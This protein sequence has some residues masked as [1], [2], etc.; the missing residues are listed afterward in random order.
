MKNSIKPLWKSALC[1]AACSAV[2][3]ACA[4]GAA[5]PG[6]VAPTP[7]LTAAAAAG[8]QASD[9]AQL[10]SAFPQVLALVLSQDPQVRGARET[11]NVALAELR[12]SRSRLFPTA[13]V[14]SSYGDA[15]QT[16][17]NT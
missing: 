13:G 1:A 9:A 7:A 6:T 17:L 8:S 12:Q 11:V 10:T 15:R 3:V 2:W 5:A 14:T 16:S 4:A